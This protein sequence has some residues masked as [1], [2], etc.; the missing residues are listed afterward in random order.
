MYRDS[1]DQYEADE[2]TEAESIY[3]KKL[4]DLDKKLQNTDRKDTV[5]KEMIERERAVLEHN[6]NAAFSVN[7][8]IGAKKHTGDM[9][10]SSA[11]FAAEDRY[12]SLS[13]FKK[14]VFILK[15]HKRKQRELD[16]KVDKHQESYPLETM[17]KTGAVIYSSFC[18]RM[19]KE[20]NKLYGRKK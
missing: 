13:S 4:A 19:V 17:T 5:S 8:A 18:D 1:W 15:G 7:A 6:R 16:K 10:V 14:L 11:Q 20:Y 3:K 12:L 9:N 2:L